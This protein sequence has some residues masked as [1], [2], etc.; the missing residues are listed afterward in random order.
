MGD[1]VTKVFSPGS[2]IERSA[3]TCLI[4]ELPKEMLASP[5]WQFEME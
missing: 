4:S 5:A 1:S 3:A 2:S